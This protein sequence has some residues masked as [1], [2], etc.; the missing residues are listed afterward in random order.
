[1]V[2][3]VV[4]PSLA[5]IALRA[6]AGT[7]RVERVLPSLKVANLV[8]LLTLNYSNAAVALPQLVAQPDWDFMALVV[9]LATTMCA[10]AFAAGKLTARSLGAARTDETA[11]MFGLGM[12]NNSAGLVLAT[13]TLSDH[14]LVFLPIVFYNLAQQI[15]AGFV[16]Y[17]RRRPMTNASTSPPSRSL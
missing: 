16:D 12:N 4:L 2:A 8:V 3:T 15:G 5:G 9:V 1:M 7:S 10:G 11:L 14:I 6:L 13:A 17:V